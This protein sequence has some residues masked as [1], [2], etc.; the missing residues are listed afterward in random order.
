MNKEKII[1]CLE[2]NGLNDIEDLNCSDEAV[3]LKF[4]YDFDDEELKASKA[5]ASD[6]CKDE[7]ESEKWY[8][9]YFLPYLS[10]LAV[11]NVGQ[12]IENIMEEVN[13]EAQYT[14]YELDKENYNYNE[15]T[16]I[17]YEKGKDIDLDKILDK[18]EE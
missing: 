18:L 14:T 16:A 10:D 3:V 15:F 13:L 1:Q 2:E 7:I 8:Y 6:E 4:F 12:I 11:D 9:D 5:Y 17:F